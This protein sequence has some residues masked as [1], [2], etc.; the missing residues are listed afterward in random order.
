MAAHPT[1]GEMIKHPY[2][3]VENY[4]DPDGQVFE[5]IYA[6]AVKNSVPN[7]E[8][9]QSNLLFGFLLSAAENEQRKEI[10]YINM[11]KN[12]FDSTLQQSVLY[13]EFLK[14]YDN[15]MSRGGGI[16]MDLSI[17]VDTIQK[18]KLGL[19]ELDKGIK[20]NF[21]I[22]K[23]INV[24]FLDKNINEEF[25][26][27]LQFTGASTSKKIIGKIDPNTTGQKIL[28]NI[29]TNIEDKMRQALTNSKINKQ[30]KE[31]QALI[32]RYEQAID[33]I[34]ILYR[35]KLEQFYTTKF[36]A[37]DDATKILQMKIKDLELAAQEYDQKQT[38][39]KAKILTNSDGD[40]RTLQQVII[41]TFTGNWGGKSVEYT[42]DIFRGGI[43]T[44]NIGGAK[45]K[46]I[47]ADNI[48]LVNATGE[49]YFGDWQ[50]REKHKLDDK[51]TTWDDISDFDIFMEQIEKIEDFESKF[52]IM[53]SAKDQS[54]GAG[55]KN[56]IAAT[57]IK[58]KGSGSLETRGPEIINMYNHLKNPGAMDPTDLV[59]S[60]ANLGED[61]V[62]HGQAE[63]AKQT[64]GAICV[65][66]MFDDVEQIVKGSSLIKG[67]NIIHLYNV[68]NYYYT[69]SDIL[70]KTA[71]SLSSVNLSQ[72]NYVKVGITS[73]PS[74][75]IYENMV[76]KNS[77]EEGMPRWNKIADTILKTNIDI[78]MNPKSL[79]NTLF[80]GVF[81]NI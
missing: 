35:T 74:G 14:L 53:Y 62:C 46:S 36:T 37:I 47:D 6:H 2:G 31:G 78:H 29:L 15:I 11:M 79:F 76:A 42:L 20:E 55:F 40:P 44:G 70:Y 21:E 54:V 39:K 67:T 52:M 8:Y 50:D 61:F 18:M 10:Q 56:S 64:L 51:G 5:G 73:I 13:K 28:D 59:F 77:P 33:K 27:A 1:V 69:L 32:A 41:N 3:V 58:I 65:G 26:K 45:G 38:S 63:Q 24:S 12:S 49:F 16:S 22:F 43:N 17:L 30:S 66:W 25:K 81:G 4:V 72:N 48:Q 9:H 7:F 80:S 68:N 60:I 34:L 57:D 23:D 19:Y 75:G 71:A